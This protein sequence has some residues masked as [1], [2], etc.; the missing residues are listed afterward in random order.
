MG[1]LEQNFRTASLE[2]VDIRNQRQDIDRETNEMN[3]IIGQADQELQQV[4]ARQERT[5]QKREAN[6]NNVRAVRGDGFDESADNMMVL[7]EC[8]REKS[9]YLLNALS[10]L[11]NN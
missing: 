2:L 11:V 9:D 10:H 7:A 8:E 3:Q 5:E 4:A 1:Q 6:H